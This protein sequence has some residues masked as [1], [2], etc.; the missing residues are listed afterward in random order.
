MKALVLAAGFGQRLEPYT[1]TTPKPLFT[2]ATRPLL[3]IVIRKLSATG[4]SA[5]TINT[6]H[7]HQQIESY[8]SEQSYDI[9][10]ATRHEPEILGTGGAIKNLA[11][12]WDSEAFMVVNS[13]ILFHTDLAAFIRFHQESDALSTL[14]LCDDTRFNQVWVDQQ[15][16]ILGF[17]LE[18][19]PGFG[20]SRAWTFTGIQI[21]DP[22][23]L[24]YIPEKVCYSVID[25][26]RTALSHNQ[27]IQAYIPKK[28]TWTDIGSPE[29]YRKAAMRTMAF[30]VLAREDPNHS[31]TCETR[32]LAGD[33][34]DRRW[35]R[36][37]TTKASIIM[38]DHG[39]R[40]ASGVREVD[41]F[42]RIGC[43][44]LGCDVKVPRILTADPFS[45]LVFL[46]DLGDQHL[47][48][49]VHD[50]GLEA[51]IVP[52]LYKTFIN[53]LI[54]MGTVCLSGFDSGWTYQSA[55]Y[56]YEMVLENECRYF[57]TAFLNDY[58]NMATGM[59]DLLAEFQAL[60]RR[61][62]A[63]QYQGFMHRDMQSRNIMVY[64]NQCYII[65][66]QGGRMGPL[67]YDLASLLI[68]P[69]V[70]LPADMATEL[71]EYYVQRLANTVNLDKL[72]FREDY[73]IC[74]LTRNLQILGA[75]GFLTQQKGKTDF[76]RY[77]PAAI[78]TLKATL[79]NEI[80]RE[81][82]GLK[83]IVAEILRPYIK[84][85]KRSLRS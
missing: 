22:Q 24:Q 30:E 41:A 1:R 21:I 18:N 73:E 55:T 26:Y 84:F 39:I 37:K 44:L 81:F 28:I 67:A 16:Q 82:P 56:D 68:D 25:A 85:Q 63:C 20:D 8:L 54:H 12:F 64:Q 65:D 57:V 66:F 9:A 46:Q 2:I 6:H 58:L 31:N 45:G 61:A 29:R 32:E 48:D 17:G 13:D 36:L 43:H 51:D 14:L 76:E 72:K 7:L 74:R 71:Y 70:V 75:F 59:E 69:Y 27:N 49:V 78:G 4:I 53:Q 40:T 42:I 38:A 10:V 83:A 34:S 19:D 52:K 11:D 79:S 23:L 77:I 33:G 62:S 60:A 3:D 47:Q 80:G 15:H 35:Y 50:K 5:I